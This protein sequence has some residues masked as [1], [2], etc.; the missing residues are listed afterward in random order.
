M[1]GKMTVQRRSLCTWTGMAVGFRSFCAVTIDGGQLYGSAW[2]SVLIGLLLAAPCAAALIALRPNGGKNMPE[3]AL[4]QTASDWGT[5]LFAAVLMLALIYDAGA[6]ISLMSS[7]ARYVAMPETNRLLMRAVTAAAVVVISM[8]G[9][10]AAANAAVM[11][12][13]LL[14]VL[15]LLLILTQMKFFRFSWITPLLGPGAEELFL[16]ALPAAGMFS[17]SAA[18]WLML[19]PEHDQEGTAILKCVLLSGLVAASLS[20]MIGMLVPGMEQEPPTRSFRIG[21][22]LANDRAGLTLE[23]PYIILLYS[24]M[25]TMLVFELTAA[26]RTA[27]IVFGRMEGKSAA[28]MT[29]SLAFLLSVSRLTEREML[30]Q[31]SLWYYPVIAAPVLLIGLTAWMKRKK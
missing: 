29:G 23:M 13:R 31:I 8:L 3:A 18:G 30:R 20:L 27:Q 25:L 6:V 19:E 12:R 16:N 22:L 9:A 24:G 1:T 14:A 4:R 10:S 11:W 7:T 17:F 15:I 2:I 26:A 5:K 21:R 28:L